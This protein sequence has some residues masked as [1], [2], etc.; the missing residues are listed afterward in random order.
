MQTSQK[1]SQEETN[2]KVRDFA[3]QAAGIIAYALLNAVTFQLVGRGVE[4]M[5]GRRG[6]LYAIPTPKKTAVG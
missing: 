3:K 5:I 4:R 6:K 2:S 1:S